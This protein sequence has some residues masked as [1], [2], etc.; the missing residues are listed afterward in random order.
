MADHPALPGPGSTMPP[1]DPPSSLGCLF[2]TCV[3]EF[4]VTAL[5]ALFLWGVHQPWWG[6]PQDPALVTWLITVTLGALTV[7]FGPWLV[8]A[9]FIRPRL[10]VLLTGL[11]ATGPLWLVLVGALAE[12]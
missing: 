5:L 2:V 1:G 3:L 9:A 10:A 7:F 6:G 8:I 11:A 12:R 4:V